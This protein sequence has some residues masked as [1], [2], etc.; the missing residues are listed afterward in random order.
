MT[1][2]KTV[3]QALASLDALATTNRD[4]ARARVAAS[5]TPTVPP[6]RASATPSVTALDHH[7]QAEQQARRE[8]EALLGAMKR[9]GIGSEWVSGGSLLGGG[10]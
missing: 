5:A 3:S 10:S 7:P 2:P 6:A 1:N 8:G 4:A 9:A